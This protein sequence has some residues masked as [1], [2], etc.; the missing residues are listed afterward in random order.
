MMRER[1]EP[2]VLVLNGEERT[3]IWR[4]WHGAVIKERRM[5]V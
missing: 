3:V 5:S 2:E 1:K 4:V